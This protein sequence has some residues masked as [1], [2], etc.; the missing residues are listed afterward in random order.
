MSKYN[1]TATDDSEPT[2]EVNQIE[3]DK[4]T[5][6]DNDMVSSVEGVQ[7]EL[8][9]NTDLE[10]LMAGIC[11]EDLSFNVSSIVMTTPIKNTDNTPQPLHASTP[12]V[13]PRNKNGTVLNNRDSISLITS[14]QHTRDVKGVSGTMPGNKISKSVVEKVNKV[15]GP[16]FQGFKSSSEVK[17]ISLKQC[18]QLTVYPEG[19]FYGLSED[20]SKCLEEF[21]GIKKLYGQYM[22]YLF[23][24][25]SHACNVYLLTF[26]MAGLLPEAS[27]SCSK[28]EFD[29][30]PAY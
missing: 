4:F 17:N 30:F 18:D 23:T 26:R 3:E 11:P 13:D 24:W 22:K 15:L 27:L 28:Q 25:L 16:D 2:C 12:E 1:D 19:T 9:T 5:I 21:K 7:N 10:E 6:N 8:S 20:V 14:E 29:L